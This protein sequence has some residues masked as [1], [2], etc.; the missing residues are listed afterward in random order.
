MMRR[1]SGIRRRRER[2]RC[3]RRRAGRPRLERRRCAADRGGHPPQYKPIASTGVACGL[4][5]GELFGLA[6][7][8]VD[9]DE[10]V[11]HLRRQVKKLRREFVFALPTNEHRADC[12]DVRGCRRDAHGGY[13]DREAAGLHVAVGEG[14][15]EAAHRQPAVPVG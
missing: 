12:A 3:L 1:S 6:E 13:P 2:S 11:I 4:R 14:R 15:R 8:G 5:Q 10:M 9:F 7:E